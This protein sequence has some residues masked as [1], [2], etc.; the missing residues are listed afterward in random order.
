MK[1]D[2]ED[3]VVLRWTA[4]LDTHLF[5]D[6]DKKFIITYYNSDGTLAIYKPIGKLTN[7]SKWKFLERGHYYLSKDSD[8]PIGPADI[9]PGFELDINGYHFKVIGPDAKT[10]ERLARNTFSLT[11]VLKSTDLW[12]P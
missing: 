10:Q 5:K 6:H 4:K 3:Q 7:E 2:N 11:M 1:A 12:R 9:H 8:T